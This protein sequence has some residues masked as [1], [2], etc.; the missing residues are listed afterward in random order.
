MGR[1]SKPIVGLD[2]EPGSIAAVQVATADGLSVERAAVVDLDPHVVRDGEVADGE[3]L[4]RALK[5]LWSQNSWLDRKV[6][7]GVANARIVVRV[8]DLPPLEDAKELDAA[9]QLHA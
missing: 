2:I 8:M 1:R 7:I 3:A 6:R 9:V 4:T 5:A